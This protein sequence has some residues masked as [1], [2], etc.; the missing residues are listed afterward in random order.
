MIPIHNM[1]KLNIFNI[2]TNILYKV[3][4]NGK[5]VLSSFHPHDLL[6]F[7]LTHKTVG[8]PYKATVYSRTN[9]LSSMKTIHLYSLHH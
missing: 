4:P 6:K 3:E 1:L 8:K 5:T 9:P 7:P 2:F